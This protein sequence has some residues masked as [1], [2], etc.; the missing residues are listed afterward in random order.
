MSGE[1]NLHFHAR[2][3]SELM[4]FA[5]LL[6]SVGNGVEIP[7]ELPAALANWLKYPC[8]SYFPTAQSEWKHLLYWKAVIRMDF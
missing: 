3:P 7:C 4:M 6:V 1:W 8:R 2:A 5:S